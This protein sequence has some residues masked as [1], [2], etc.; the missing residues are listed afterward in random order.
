L[1]SAVETSLAKLG[2]ILLGFESFF[3]DPFDESILLL[4]LASSSSWSVS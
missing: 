3:G 4:P 2:L 1:G